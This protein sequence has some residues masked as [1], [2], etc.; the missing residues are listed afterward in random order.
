MTLNIVCHLLAQEADCEVA[1]SCAIGDDE[2]E[3]RY[4][5]AGRGGGE[6]M[7]YAEVVEIARGY[8]KSVGGFEKLAEWGLIR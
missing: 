1:A 5:D 4:D 2:V 8:V 6:T 7:S 3:F